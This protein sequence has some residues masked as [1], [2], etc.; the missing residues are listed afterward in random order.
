MQRILAIDYG[1]RRTGLA[2]ADRETRLPAPLEVFEGLTD[3]QLV[4]RIAELVVRE[5]IGTIV[6]GM[7]LNED[8]SIGPQAKKTEQFVNLLQQRTGREIIHVDERLTTHDSE[9]KLSG[10]YTRKQKRRRIDAV[11][12]ARILQDYLDGL[13]KA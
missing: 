13:N 5:E 8:G 4:E 2:V 11:A 7:P 10:I 12:A 6:C 1:L 3:Q 9:K